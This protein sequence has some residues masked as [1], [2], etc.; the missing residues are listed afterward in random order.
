MNTL[1]LILMGCANQF[2]SCIDKERYDKELKQLEG[3]SESIK[4]PKKCLSAYMI[5]VKEVGD[6]SIYSIQ[7][8]KYP[9]EGLLGSFVNEEKLPAILLFN[10][11]NLL[12]L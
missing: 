11:T 2:I 5:F 1:V 12:L 9:V 3:Q 8:V 4:K 6:S 10:S 7:N